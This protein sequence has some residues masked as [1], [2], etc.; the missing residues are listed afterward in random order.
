MNSKLDM[1]KLK[2]P[3][4]D[5]PTVNVLIDRKLDPVKTDI[6][7]LRTQVNNYTINYKQPKDPTAIPPINYATFF[8]YNYRCSV[9]LC[10][11]NKK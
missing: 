11:Q 3:P 7:S 6:N 4:I 10:R 9:D 8:K 5:E 2:I 1:K